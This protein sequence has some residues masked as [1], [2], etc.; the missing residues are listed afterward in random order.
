MTIPSDSGSAEHG[1][2]AFRIPHAP[3]A[4]YGMGRQVNHDPRS[5]QFAFRAPPKVELRAVR[6]ERHVPIFDQG[7]LGSCTGNAAVGCL[8]TGEYFATINE[9]DAD[10]LEP[11]N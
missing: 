7:N 8:A 1:G 5:R 2:P 9:A 6:Y 4:P 3:D 10:W 11:L